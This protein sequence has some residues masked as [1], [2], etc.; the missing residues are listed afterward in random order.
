MAVFGIVASFGS[1][2]YLGVSLMSE[3]SFAMRRDNMPS[4]AESTLPLSTFIPPIHARRRIS[5]TS[6]LRNPC[7]CLMASLAASSP[8][9]IGYPLIFLSATSAE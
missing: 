7:A 8:V 3:A 6:A 2:S 9:S 4:A 1:R 5:C